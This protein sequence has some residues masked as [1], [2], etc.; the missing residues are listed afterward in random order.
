MAQRDGNFARAWGHA[1][2]H[3][4]RLALALL[5]ATLLLLCLPQQATAEDAALQDLG[6]H[7]GYAITTV[8]CAVCHAE[9]Q[10]ESP[11]LTPGTSC[12]FCHTAAY[13]GGGAVASALISWSGG[14]PH[15]ES[16]TSDDCHGGAHGVGASIY[17][18]PASR[19]LTAKA[20]DKLAAD[21]LANAVAASELA[22]YSATTRVLATGAVCSRAGC[23]E[24]SAFGIVTAGASLEVTGVTGLDSMDSHVTG[25]RVIASQTA[26]WNADL[27]FPTSKTNLTIAYAPV[28]YCSSCHDLVDDN[29][30]GTPAFP[31]AINGIVDSSAG[32]DGSWRAAVWLTAGAFAGDTRIAVGEYNAS[33]EKAPAASAAGPSILDGVCLKCHRGSTSTGVGFEY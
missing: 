7:G 23:H 27:S 30:G 11:L 32:F 1:D 21:A 6:P 25:H 14:G 22:T 18:G 5:C 12:T 33:G 3:A 28:Q 8:K 26:T 4:L 20:D 15:D 24:N 2:H 9:H 16:C 13:F 10:G 31:H 17:Y 29:N 19:L